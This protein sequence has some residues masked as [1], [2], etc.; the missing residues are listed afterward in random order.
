MQSLFTPQALLD[1]SQT[2]SPPNAL[3][4]PSNSGVCESPA[5]FQTEAAPVSR[6]HKMSLLAEAKR[7]AAE[8]EYSDDDVRKAVGEFIFEM[9][10]SSDRWQHT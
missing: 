8:F 7:I 4:E 5:P 6:P 10:E 2:T 3:F 1:S 9:S